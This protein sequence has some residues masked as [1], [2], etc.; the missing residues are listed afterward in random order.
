VIEPGKTESV[1]ANMPAF[2]FGKVGKL[3]PAL[4]KRNTAKERL[5]QK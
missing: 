5:S 1:Y 2:G 4:G 3:Q